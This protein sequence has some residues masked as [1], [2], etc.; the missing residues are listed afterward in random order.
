MDEQKS[1]RS[2]IIMGII[3]SLCTLLVIYFGMALYF[4]NHF[5][6]GSAINSINISGKTVNQV[7][8]QIPSELKAYTLNLKARGGKIEQIKGN[9]I[10]L[11]YNSV[12]K[13]Q[14]LKDKQNSL[15]WI[16]VFF[17]TK[18]YKMTEEISYDKE[19]LKKIIDKISIFNNSNIIEPKNPDLKYTDNGYII[20]AGVK[21]N[22]IN[23]DVLY[24]KVGKAI[25]N[26]ESTIDLESINCYVNAQYTS[27]SPKIVDIKNMLN[28][29]VYSKIT[30]TFGERKEIID[31]SIINKWINV[32]ENFGVTFD[33]KKIKSYLIQLSNTYDTIG[34]TRD[35]L[36][37]SGKTIKISGGDYGWS[38]NS[39]KETQDLIINIK[40][41]QNITR[42]PAYIQTALAHN[43][44]DVG[45]TYVEI[46]MSKQHLWFYK[47]GSLVVQGDVVTG[48]LSSKH[49][50]PS[51]IYMLK[52]KQRNTSLKGQDYNAPV[53]YWMPFNGGIGIHDA[54]WRSVFGGNIYKTNGSHGC[55]N[56]PYYLAQ[57]VFNNIKEGNPV[58][59]YY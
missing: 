2:K 52:Y 3:I 32:D 22:K 9:D 12:G 47:N 30:Y 54:S 39:T 43:N 20:I 16:S 27:D 17:N 7:K 33:E 13:V 25:L 38:I 24:D 58:I 36:T 46:D 19:L 5:Y 37:T 49:S 26:D 35:F 50:T 59:C 23:K 57:A 6:F 51:G 53:S 42:E 56:A 11:K 55:I 14:E 10:G 48:N 45:N 31:G 18:D 34:K 21:G 40:E 4:M 29:Y 41:G 44:N 1:K 28:K 8:E 15:E